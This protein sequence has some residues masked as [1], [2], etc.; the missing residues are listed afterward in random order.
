MRSLALWGALPLVR[1][2][3]WDR[4]QEDVRALSGVA[5]ERC[6]PSE[7]LGRAL[8]APD[9][10]AVWGAAAQRLRCTSRGGGGRCRRAFLRWCADVPQP[11]FRSVCAGVLL[12]EAVAPFNASACVDAY[13]SSAAS[14]DRTC[15][16]HVRE[17]GC[18][19]DAPLVDVASVAR[20]D[21]DVFRTHPSVSVQRWGSESVSRAN[22][23]L[24]CALCLAW[25]ARFL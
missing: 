5:V 22:V 8:R 25:C 19:V 23:A 21:D 17:V 24:A 9:T 20:G 15:Y 12:R 4:V 14:F 16:D 11:R 3:L 10:D 13:C 1:G 7:A 6:T 2:T 18:D